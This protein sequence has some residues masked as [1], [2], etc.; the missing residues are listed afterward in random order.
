MPFEKGK[1]GNPRGR[2]RE[3]PFLDALRIEIAAAG[4]D[5]KALREAGR[6][7]L[8]RARK[9]DL[10]AINILADRLDGKPVQG[11]ENADPDEP[12]NVVSRIERVIV[13]APSSDGSAPASAPDL[14]EDDKTL[15]MEVLALIRRSVP[16]AGDKPPAAIMNVIRKALREHFGEAA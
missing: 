4:E 5:Q 8:D 11:I 1:S 6:K 15:L 2:G 7:L 9:G 14:S 13:K 3:K 12:F 10:A 16:R